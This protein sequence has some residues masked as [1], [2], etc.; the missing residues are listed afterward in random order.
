VTAI[1]FCCRARLRAG[2]LGVAGA[3]KGAALVAAAMQRQTA[4][5]PGDVGVVE[6]RPSV[7]AAMRTSA[8]DAAV[9]PERR[10][11]KTAPAD[12]A[13]SVAAV[14]ATVPRA[15]KRIFASID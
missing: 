8:A 13:V 1:R 4:A 5:T 10:A 7:E 12:R 3:D 2:V 14:A 6:K 9:G 15:S 11:I